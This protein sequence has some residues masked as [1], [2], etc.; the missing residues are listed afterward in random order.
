MKFPK[1]LGFLF[2]L[3]FVCIGCAT[4]IGM[5]IGYAITIPLGF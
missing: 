1:S 3:A 2:V 4:L 5:L